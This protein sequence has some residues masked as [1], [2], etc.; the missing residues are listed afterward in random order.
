M[1]VGTPAH[2]SEIRDEYGDVTVANPLTNDGVPLYTNT[3]A[4]GTLDISLDAYGAASLTLTGNLTLTLSGYEAGKVKSIV[5]KFT[6][7]GTGSR[8]LAA[9]AKVRWVGGTDEVLS[10]AASSVDLIRYTSFGEDV[11]YAEKLGKA[12]AA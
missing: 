5:V 2:G 3:A 6:Q 7:D 4:T 9:N 1:P 12:Y 8:L 11:Y 10:T